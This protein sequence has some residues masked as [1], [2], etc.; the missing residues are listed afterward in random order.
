MRHYQS[1]YHQT[2]LQRRLKMWTG[3]KKVQFNIAHQREALQGHLC[4]KFAP[5]GFNA[6]MTPPANKCAIT[7]QLHNRKMN[8]WFGLRFI[9][10]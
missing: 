9:M 10:H 4:I 7:Q 2:L 6:H 8:H 5:V 3:H 1:E